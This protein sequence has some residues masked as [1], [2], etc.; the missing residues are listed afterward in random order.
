VSSLT[1]SLDARGQVD[2]DPGIVCEG[3]AI[4]PSTGRNATAAIH[5]LST[6]KSGEF[7]LMVF[8]GPSWKTMPVKPVLEA[9]LAKP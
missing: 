6:G 3:A 8:Y 4:S 7:S 5:H 9:P 2:P 1:P